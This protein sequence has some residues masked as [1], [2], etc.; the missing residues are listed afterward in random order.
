[1]ALGQGD[2]DRAR[3]T[4][5]PLL[6]M[7]YQSDPLCPPERFDTLRQ[8]FRGRIALIEIDD[9]PQGHS[10]LAW[11]LNDDALGDAMKYLKICLGVDRRGQNMKLAK[12]DGRNCEMTA[13][14]QW[15]AL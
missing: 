3:Q 10:A 4:N 13:K 2:I 5:I 6:A 1:L 14:G 15:R 12:L 9:E 11:D 8:M 7:R